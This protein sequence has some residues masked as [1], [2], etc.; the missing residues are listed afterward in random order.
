MIPSVMLGHQHYF[1]AEPGQTT[2]KCKVNGKKCACRAIASKHCEVSYVAGVSL[3]Y[4]LDTALVSPGPLFAGAGLAAMALLLCALAHL[5]HHRSRQEAS[6]EHASASRVPG[7]WST[8]H[9]TAALPM[10]W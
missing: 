8:L 9:V 6:A 3:N 7:A 4:A 1:H 10:A 2:Q 5:E